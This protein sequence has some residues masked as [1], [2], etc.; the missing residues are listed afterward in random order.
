MRIFKFGN[1]KIF[2]TT[3]LNKLVI[4]YSTI[5][6]CIST[7]KHIIASVTGRFKRRN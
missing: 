1:V 3:L 7:A 5:R 6:S 4:N 2:S